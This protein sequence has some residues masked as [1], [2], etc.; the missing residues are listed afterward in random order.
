MDWVTLTSPSIREYDVTIEAA[1]RV[2]A[3]VVKAVTVRT[4]LILI[5]RVS[6]LTAFIEV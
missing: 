4:T 2:G 3:H 1:A 6:R 5:R